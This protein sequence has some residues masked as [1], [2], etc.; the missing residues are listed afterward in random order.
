[1]KKVLNESQLAALIAETTKT[2][3]SE[4]TINDYLRMH[5]LTA[6]NDDDG[7][8]YILAKILVG[9]RGLPKELQALKREAG[10]GKYKLLNPNA[11]YT[12]DHNY[13]GRK[14]FGLDVTEIIN[15]YNEVVKRAIESAKREAINMQA[16][17]RGFVKVYPTLRTDDSFDSR[18]EIWEED[19]RWGVWAR[20]MLRTTAHKREVSKGFERRQ[21]K[22]NWD[23]I[24]R[25]TAAALSGMKRFFNENAETEEDFDKVCKTTMNGNRW[26]V[27]FEFDEP[28]TIRK[29][30]AIAEEET[31][32]KAMTSE[33]ARNVYMFKF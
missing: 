32:K 4:S 22:Y 18:I 23:G 21:A 33:T 13:P 15:K 24:N 19:G 11:A 6:R 7:E 30:I 28:D 25:L 9:F 12:K 29:M 14:Y 5:G 20:M 1:M 2:V 16:E 3:L 26:I 10:D 31:G 27:Q 8:K 17:M